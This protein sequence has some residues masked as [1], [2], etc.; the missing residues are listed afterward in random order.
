MGAQ[1]DYGSTTVV[2]SRG[3]I[4]KEINFPWNLSSHRRHVTKEEGSFMTEEQKET[5]PS[6]DVLGGTIRSLRI[7]KER[8]VEGEKDLIF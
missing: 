6:T 8:T 4:R 7:Y 1:T 3:V 5:T 2:E